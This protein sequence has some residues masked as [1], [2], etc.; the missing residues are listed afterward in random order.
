MRDLVT[1]LLALGLF[2]MVA[3][4]AIAFVLKATGG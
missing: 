4:I 1:V 2:A 3:W